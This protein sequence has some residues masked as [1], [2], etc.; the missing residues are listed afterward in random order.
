MKALSLWQPWAS[1]MADGRK[2]IETR[3]WPPPVWLI[4]QNY[5]IHATMKV[6]SDACVDFGY[7][8]LTIPRGCIVSIHRLEKFVKF[9]ENSRR[10]YGDAY[11]DFEMG[12]YGWF[13]PLVLKLKKPIAVK[14][15]QGL[16]DWP[17]FE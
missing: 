4:G 1:L 2:L 17:E 8:P 7:D 12:R 16:F 11:G 13:S 5:A 9:D 3:S 6:D 15:H 14:G 10:D